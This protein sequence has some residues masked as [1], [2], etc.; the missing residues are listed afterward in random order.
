MAVRKSEGF[1]FPCTDQVTR[2]VN[3]LLDGIIIFQ[4]NTTFLQDLH[5][6]WYK[7]L[8]FTVVCPVFKCPKIK[9]DK[10]FVQF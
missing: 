4:I 2:L 5:I 1:V 10:N 3:R 9:Q 6:I 7:V 8:M